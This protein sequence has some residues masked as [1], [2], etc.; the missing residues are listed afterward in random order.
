MIDM[1]RTPPPKPQ[2]IIQVFR[3][4]NQSAGASANSDD[5]IRAYDKVIRFCSDTASCRTDGSLKTKMLLYWAYNNVADAYLGKKDAKSALEYLQ[6]GMDFAR[7]TREVNSVL[8]KMS[9]VYL[10]IGDRLK[11][12]DARKRI[13]ENLSRDN[14]REEYY[15]LAAEVQ[16]PAERIELLEQALQAAGREKLPVAEKCRHIETI[17]QNLTVLYKQQGDE[18]NLQRIRNLSVNSENLCRQS[19][20]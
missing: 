5:K 7:D 10:Q 17:C 13:I 8:R 9:D 12:L 20:L 16:N 2:N 4:A 3:L 14:Q 1:E 15:N 6:K 19:E 18:E 11:W